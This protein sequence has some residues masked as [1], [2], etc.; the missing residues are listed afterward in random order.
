[1]AAP[2]AAAG[3]GPA[4]GPANPVQQPEELV[5]IVDERNNVVRP[6]RPSQALHVPSH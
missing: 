5:A 6:A 4:G 1:M 2:T 3:S